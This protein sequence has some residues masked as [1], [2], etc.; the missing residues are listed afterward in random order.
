MSRMI[1]RRTLAAGAFL[2]AATA[3]VRA[4]D[5][6]TAN[7]DRIRI[8]IAAGYWHP[9]LDAIL[10]G[11]AAGQ[12]GTAI[13]LK[14][15][16][17]YDD[18]GL[19]DVHLTVWPARKHQVKF[20]YFPIKNSSELV[21]KRDLTFVGGSYR[22]GETINSTLDWKTYRF[23]YQYDVVQRRRGSV[24]A[25]IELRQ[26]DLQLRLTSSS[27]NNPGRSRI[28]TPGLGVAG[29]V[30]ATPRLS[31]SAEATAFAVPD[32]A[33]RHYGGHYIDFSGGATLRVVRHLSAQGGLRSIDIRHLGATNTGKIKL[34]GPYVRAL[35]TY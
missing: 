34:T 9:G 15:D 6:A 1:W 27:A 10:S 31:F 23:V 29:Q 8:E 3:A 28:P 25:I 26:T 2:L 32:R 13:N 17:D 18:R 16:L 33:D 24:G 12:I 7:Q 11:D 5:T 22:A 4:T 21:L 14:S 20:E 35:L 30:N 19:P